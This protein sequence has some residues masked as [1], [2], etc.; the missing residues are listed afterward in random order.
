MK[1][2]YSKHGI[3]AII[4]AAVVLGAFVSPQ[5]A[6]AS[7]GIQEYPTSCEDGISFSGSLDSI[8]IDT[9]PWDIADEF[10]QV[11]KNLK[12]LSPACAFARI[13]EGT[14][15]FSYEHEKTPYRPRV[16]QWI[17]NK[18]NWEPIETVMNRATNTISAELNNARGIIG[19]FVSPR[20]SYE[21]I[22]SWYHHKRY[23]AGA[24]TNIY[25]IGTKLR[26]TNTENKKFTVV[27]VTSTWTNKNNKRI[28]DL[29]SAAFSKIGNLQT[30]L[31]PVRIEKI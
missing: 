11:H 25:P 10:M 16:Y 17:A 24:A 7:A 1:L 19:V 22:A 2:E 13:G 5:F 27:T 29:V 28:I 4:G 9:I 21:G 23:P 14:I 15:N 26:V 8:I 3:R 31:I 20:D 30:G 18:Q 12:A 6:F